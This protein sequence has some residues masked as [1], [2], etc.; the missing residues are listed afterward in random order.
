M[1]N[2]NVA[3]AFPR[4]DLE[5]QVTR[6]YNTTDLQELDEVVLEISS[7]FLWGKA[8]KAAIGQAYHVRKK[9]LENA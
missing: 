8:E 4:G 7:N 1:I 2:L 5:A 9:E 3:D 6:M